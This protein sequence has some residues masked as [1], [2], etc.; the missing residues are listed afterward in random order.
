MKF[1]HLPSLGYAM[2]GE[3]NPTPIG[4]LIISTSE[5]GLIGLDF[6]TELSLVE[7]SLM[8]KGYTIV[9]EENPLL[10][11]AKVEISEYFSGKRK[12]F[13]IPIDWSVLPAFQAKV[14]KATFTIPY[15]STR[16]YAEIAQQIGHPG[17]A[18]AVGRAE[19][20]NPIPII[21]PCHRVIGSDGKLHGF[22]APGGLQTK[23]FLLQ[24]E[25]AL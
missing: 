2:L 12:N 22:G 19:A 14:L 11:K 17:A 23:A 9:R 18:R 24:H 6:Q 21:I 5:Q 15:G 3:I 10:E 8:N 7:Q 1:N 20:K 13:S 25:G 16:T 4:S